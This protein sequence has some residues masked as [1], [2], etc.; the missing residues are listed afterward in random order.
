MRI[1]ISEIREF[2]YQEAQ[3]IA[4]VARIR[5][6]S[7]DRELSL[8]LS[9]P[10]EAPYR[11]E[12]VQ[13]LEYVISGILAQM[14]DDGLSIVL[15]TDK[16]TPCY[17]HP[18]A[19]VALC[20]RIAEGLTYLIYI[21]KEDR[22]SFW[23]AEEFI[24]QYYWWE[25]AFRERQRGQDWHRILKNRIIEKEEVKEN[26][27]ICDAFQKEWF[28]QS[29]LDINSLL[30]T[31]ER[32]DYGR[33]SSLTLPDLLKEWE[34][35]GSRL[36]EQIRKKWQSHKKRWNRMYK[37]PFGFTLKEIIS[38]I[39]LEDIL[40]E[41]NSLLKRSQSE[42]QKLQSDFEVLKQDIEWI[43]WGF[44]SNY[45]HFSS[46]IFQTFSDDLVMRFLIRVLSY[47]L[48]AF[49]RANSQFQWEEENTIA[50]WNRKLKEM[51]TR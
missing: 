1:S 25:E 13:M 10:D 28:L 23:K 17:Y 32:L 40:S 16:T 45:A 19:A 6:S 8:R 9:K 36:P 42:L 26:K 48:M 47:L 44:F 20:R 34:S 49:D 43:G 33:I 39:K 30:E 37:Y 15:L 3:K 46:A 18:Q 27:K 12:G 50:K 24:L 4:K 7:L 41:E 14:A 11:Y 29:I 51:R 5:H 21:L 31:H 38:C 2:L 35:W 22:N